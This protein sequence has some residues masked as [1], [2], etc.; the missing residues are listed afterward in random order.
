MVARGA[1]IHDLDLPSEGVD[2]RAT[3]EHDDEKRIGEQ[4]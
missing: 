3:R 1:T 4:V 2:A